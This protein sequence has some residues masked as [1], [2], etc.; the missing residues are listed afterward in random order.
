MEAQRYPND[1]DGIIA[2]APANAFT[3]ILTGFAWYMQNTL[4]DPASYIPAK[5]LKAIEAAVLSACDARDDV[6]DGVL[7][8]P[9]KCGFDR[10][11]LLCK[12]EQTDDCLTAEQ[13]AART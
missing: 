12:G 5:K 9:T 8:D 3:Y 7:D 1:Y 10:A 6:K 2:G 13:V 4:V 11:V